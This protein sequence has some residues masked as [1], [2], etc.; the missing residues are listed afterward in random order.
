MAESAEERSPS[1][2][3]D[4]SWHLPAEDLWTEEMI[5]MLG[6]DPQKTLCRKEAN[7]EPRTAGS[8]LEHPCWQMPTWG[9]RRLQEWECAVMGVLGPAASE[10]PS[11]QLS[12]VPL[13]PAVGSC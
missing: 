9:S 2:C 11:Q 13:P 5:L 7:W 8:S 6:S 1:Q 12:A 4:A 10:A 3:D